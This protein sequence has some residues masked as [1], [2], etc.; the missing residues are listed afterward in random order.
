MKPNNLGRV[1]LGFATLNPTYELPLVEMTGRLRTG[2]LPLVEMTGRLFGKGV[3]SAFDPFDFAALPGTT[4]GLA[5]RMEFDFDSDFDLEG[6][7]RMF[8][9]HRFFTDRLDRCCLT[10]LL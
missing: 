5:A 2:F 1:L 4:I 8:F 10:I 3:K 6:G 9:F 7:V